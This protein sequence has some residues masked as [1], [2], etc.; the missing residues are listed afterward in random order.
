[1]SKHKAVNTNRKTEIER[2]RTDQSLQRERH[3]TDDALA[4]QQK[5]TQDLADDIVERAREQAD[6]ILGVAR[7]RADQK[8]IPDG[9][10]G[11]ASNGD[12]REV[13]AQERVEEDVVLKQER[14]SAD[15]SLRWERAEQSRILAA[16]LPLERERTDRS[17]L[18]ERGLVDDAIVN[19]DDLMGMVGH[20][21]QNLLAGIATHAR[22]LAKQASASAEGQRTLL[23]VDRIERYVA[24]M[25]RL[26][27]DLVDVTS[28]DAGKF[29]VH[30][31][32][33]DVAEMISEAIAPFA[34]SAQE[35]GLSLEFATDGSMLPGV[36]DRQ[37]MLQVMANLI[38]NA[39][40]FTHSGGTI[41]LEVERA[42]EDLRVSVLDTGEG[43]VEDM[44]ESIF[45]RFGQAGGTNQPGLGL[46]LYI[47]KCIVEAQGG[48]IWAESNPTGTGSAFRF[49]IPA[50]TSVSAIAG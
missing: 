39:M 46:G 18:T 28:V 45:E 50:Y 29:A 48:R 6:E 49:T 26:I 10:G 30:P 7:Q 5:H 11:G 47:S 32:P 23:G 31:K 27:G 25:N 19:R 44:R 40:K 15:D 34:P 12:A 22:I 3:R 41:T 20:D 43:I 35:K 21:L 4:V 33:G 14:A 16:L 13:V 9:P 36:F 37:R 17:L 8:L 38:A 2:A 42:G 1:M 24:C